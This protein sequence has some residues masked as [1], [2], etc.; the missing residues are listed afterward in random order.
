MEVVEERTVRI[1]TN[2]PYPGETVL[3]G[4]SFIVVARALAARPGVLLCDDPVAALDVSLSA[5]VL[6]LLFDL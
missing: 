4:G 2:D 6:N 5:R 1:H 3:D